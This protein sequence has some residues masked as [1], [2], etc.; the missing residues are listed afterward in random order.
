MA[1]HKAEMGTSALQPAGRFLLIIWELARLR[2]G[3]IPSASPPH[4]RQAAL[5]RHGNE[6]VGENVWCIVA[7]TVT[8]AHA[9]NLAK[10]SQADPRLANGV[11]G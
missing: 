1:C 9:S 4:S 10:Q 11:K 6:R 5:S 2:V 8:T 3:E 7:Q